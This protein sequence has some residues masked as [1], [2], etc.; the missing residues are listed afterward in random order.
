MPQQCPQNLS[1]SENPEM[2]RKV[3][4]HAIRIINEVKKGMLSHDKFDFTMP[5]K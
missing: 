2:L 4:E 1:R 5:L 3:I